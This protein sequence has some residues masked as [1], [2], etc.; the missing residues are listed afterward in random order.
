[1]PFATTVH[2]RDQILDAAAQLF[3]ERGFTATSMNAIGERLGV[4]G[5]AIYGHFDGKHE[6]LATLVLNGVEGLL[7]QAGDPLDD[8]REDLAH[9]VRT[10]VEAMLR[11]RSLATLYVT[12]RNSLTAELGVRSRTG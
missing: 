2:P 11:D 6:I 8:P 9:L 1:M 7:D 10:H 5:P 3:A 12:E 4:S